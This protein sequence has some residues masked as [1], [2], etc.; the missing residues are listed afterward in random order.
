MTNWLS[1]YPSWPA[2]LITCWSQWLVYCTSKSYFEAWTLT[3]VLALL[4]NTKCC[5]RD[6]FSSINFVTYPNLC[7]LL[8]R[9]FYVTGQ[10]IHLWIWARCR[11]DKFV[12]YFPP[13]SCPHFLPSKTNK[14]R[15]WSKSIV[16]LVTIKKTNYYAKNIFC[17]CTTCTVKLI[18]NSLPSTADWIYPAKYNWTIPIFLHTR[19]WKNPFSHVL[20]PGI[21]DCR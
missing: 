19:L 5:C 7:I 13:F 18:R 17:W 8:A 12:Y 10:K 6:Q 1:K 4:Y 16:K 21:S 20:L 11:W 3:T 15:T 14:R 2:N 9:S